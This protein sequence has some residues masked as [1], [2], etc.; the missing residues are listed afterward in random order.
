MTESLNE[1]AAWLIERV[2]ALEECYE[3][4]EREIEDQKPMIPSSYKKKH[5][6]ILLVGETWSPRRV[7]SRR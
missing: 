6:N 7:R 4:V 5:W 1:M 2:G 3:V